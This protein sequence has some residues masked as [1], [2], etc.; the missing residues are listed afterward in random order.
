[1]RNSI[2]KSTLML[3]ILLLVFSTQSVQSQQANNNYTLL[4]KS[5]NYLLSENFNSFISNNDLKNLPSFDGRHYCF[6]QFNT[7]PFQNERESIESSGIKLL[8][9]LPNYTYIASIP[10]NYDCQTLKEYNIRSISKIEADHKLS[11]SLLS[12]SFSDWAINVDGSLSINVKYFKGIDPVAVK[13]ILLDE[14]IE[15]IAAHDQANLLTLSIPIDDLINI[16]ELPFIMYMEEIPHPPVPDDTEARSLHRV[17][18]VNSAYAAGRHYDGTGVVCGLAD[19]GAIGPHIDY[20]GRLTQHTIGLGGSHGDMTAGILMGCGNLD[21]T[22]VGSAPGSYLNMYSING[23]PHINNAQSNFLTLGTVI[24]STSY[25]QNCGGVYDTDASQGDRQIRENPALIHVFSAGNAGNSDCGYGAGAGWGNITGGYKAAKNVIACGN[26]DFLG[27]LSNSSSHGPAADGRIKPDICANG[28]DQ[29]STAEGNDYQVGGG[30]SAAAPSIAGIVATL[31]HAYRVLHNGQNPETSLLKA[32][33]LNTTR[34]KGNPGPD[35][36]FGWGRVNTLKAVKVLE[37]NRYTSA[38]IVQDS[39]NTHVIN[40]PAGLKQLRVMLYWLDQEGT[41]NASKALVNDLNLQLIDPGNQPFNPW[42][43]D[44]TPNPVTLDLPAVRGIDTLNNMEQVTIDNPP[45]GNFT[46]EVHGLLVPQGPQ[47]YYILYEFLTDE[48]DV[49]YPLGGEAFAP[50]ETQTIRWDAHGD[51]LG[52]NIELSADSGATWNTIANNINGAQRFFNWTIPDILTGDA[53]IKVSRGAQ[54]DMGE[55]V[56]TIMKIP[57]NLNIDWA[58]PDTC[59]MSW[60][61][62]QGARA[63]EVSWLGNMYMDSIGTVISSPFG[64]SPTASMKIGGINPVDDFWFSVKA[65]GP[66][67]A[68][69]RRANAIHKS[70]GVFNCVIPVDAE[71]TSLRPES[72]TIQNCQDYSSVTVEVTLKNSGLSDIH[73]IDVFYRLDA[74]PVVA[75]NYIDTIASGNLADYIFTVPVDLSIIGNHSLTAWISYLSDGNRYNDTLVSMINT[76]Q[77]VTIST[78]TIEDMESFTLCNTQSN[79][80]ATICPLENGWINVINYEGDDIDWRTNSG[81]TPS[82]NTGPSYDHTLGNSSGKYIYLEP[83]GDCNY[84]EAK[85]ISPCIDLTNNPNPIIEFWY[86]MNGNHMG[87]L[88]LDILSNQSWDLDVMVPLTGNNGNVWIQKTIDL[89]AYSGQIINIRFRGITGSYYQ[90][91]MALDDINITRLTGI[92]EESVESNIQ[93][94]PNPGNGVFHLSFNDLEANNIEILLSD[95]SGRILYNHK[96][97]DVTNNFK[98]TLDLSGF[99]PGVYF[100]NLKSDGFTHTR[101]IIIQ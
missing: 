99:A 88:H 46:A 83:S 90:S 68:I 86:H 38:N 26:L 62:V 89:S 74:N 80:E 58:C 34:D 24:T 25:S 60:D 6:I 75:E 45:A 66:G 19:D 48:I 2:L 35:Y 47:K 69:G 20:Q 54:Y 94:Y 76:T 14:G 95:P 92:Q 77:G 43:L 81:Q 11:S 42:I 15:I 36:S 39:L 27:N 37:E 79:C 84:K 13:S 52:F 91:D 8:D 3:I 16:T 29:L 21:P 49:T 4:L 32:C 82:N 67:N 23:Y 96:L 22:I 31:Y 85:L 87:V 101:R 12:Q 100:V 41:P 30:T 10:V 33:L 59:Q 56:F 97:K 93:L 1:M 98:T 65:L 51:S 72:S 55:A 73:N 63:Y 5:G 70:P 78:D 71:L 61:T 7:I 64:S 40:V 57:Q 9:Y 50:N 44:P 53:L 18:A 28:V 17:N